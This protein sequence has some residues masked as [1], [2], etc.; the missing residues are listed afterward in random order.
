MFK[1][2]FFVLIG[3]L[4][5]WLGAILSL[6]IPGSEVP[7][8]MQTLAVILAGALLGPV[9]G[10]AA[11]GLYLLAGGLGLPVFAGGRSGIEVLL[12][13]TGGFLLGFLLTSVLV[14]FIWNKI[15]SHK[16][17]WPW[18]IF[19]LAHFLILLIG[20]LWLQSEQGEYHFPMQSLTKLLPGLL[21][22][23][24]LGGLILY[25]YARFVKLKK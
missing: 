15:Q 12:G 2:I 19:L 5:I 25:L 8:S 7:V 14:G 9:R 13:P 22:K 16:G 23:V 6:P 18:I 24:G 11:V 1:S 20:F 3:A 4:S 17:L 21:F 10:G